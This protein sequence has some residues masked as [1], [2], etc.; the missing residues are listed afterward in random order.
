MKFNK[1]GQMMKFL[2]ALILSL[3]LL[4]VFGGPAIGKT[5]GLFTSVSDRAEGLFSDCDNDGIEN[6]FD[7]CPCLD[8][9]VNA[10]TDSNKYLGCPDDVGKNANK[11]KD[12]CFKYFESTVDKEKLK[13]INFDEKGV[14][15][16]EDCEDSDTCVQRCNV[17]QQSVPEIEDDNSQGIDVNSDLILVD[18][19]VDDVSVNS[20]SVIDKNL[21][22]KNFE[23]FGVKTLIRVEGEDVEDSFSLEFL[24]CRRQSQNDCKVMDLYADADKNTKLAE[25]KIIFQGLNSEGDMPTQEVF[26]AVGKNDFC[27]IPT[28]ENSLD[29]SCIV[30]AKIDSNNGESV[31]DE[32]SEGN[33]EK[34]VSFILRGDKKELDQFNKY[35]I[36]VSNENEN[37]KSF[38]SSTL[39]ACA[40][41][42]IE[43]YAGG[44]LESTRGDFPSKKA[45][46]NGCWIFS[47]DEKDSFVKDI[48]GASFK[49]SKILSYIDTQVLDSEVVNQVGH[50][51]AISR[52]ED[53]IKADSAGSLICKEGDWHICNKEGNN[54]NLVI[55][56][57]GF[58]CKDF[59]WSQIS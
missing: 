31:L 14:V 22:G 59:V 50:S 51:D 37:I 19:L 35:Y 36:L 23:F 40:S 44:T 3:L 33:N 28:S 20:D 26:I 27:N 58:S 34:K 9:R 49:E 41:N 4:V 1:K 53:P 17:V 5:L 39:N 30:K 13:G 32:I 54:K 29:Y 16:K 24:S 46:N 57:K 43:D 52:F 25:N 45:R 18:F 2:I 21:N 10:H 12:T 7:R 42:F 56:T 38:C 15:S 48:G 6:E 11:D 8:D 47:I 55:G